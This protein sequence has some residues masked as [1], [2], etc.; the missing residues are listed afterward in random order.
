MLT[1]AVCLLVLLAV[2]TLFYHQASVQVWSVASAIALVLLFRFNDSLL[3]NV[4]STVLVA[5]ILLPLSM[6][7]IRRKYFSKKAFA[8]FK[9]IMPSMSET[10]KEAL[11]AGTVTWEGD[12]FG[13][14]PDISALFK[15]TPATL[16]KREKT[17]L[18]KEVNALC[19]LVNDWKVTHEDLDLSEETWQYIKD[20][21]FLGM[22]IPESYGGLNF[23]ASAQS[24]IL[25]R[26]YSVSVTLGTTVCVPN[27]LGPAELL[28]KY[29]TKAQKE[30][31][32]PRLAKG[33]DIPCF[34]LTGPNAGSDAASIPDTGIICRDTFNGEEVIGIRLNW[35]KRYITLAPVATVLGLA[36]RLFDPENL[37][38]DEEDIGITCALIPVETK[39]VEIGRR[40]F[41][42]NTSFMNGPTK[43]KDVFIPLDY[44]I[45]GQSMAGSGW[46]MLMECLGA[47]RAISLPSSAVGGCQMATFVT[48]AYA[49]VRE[50]FGTAI[51]NFEG[52]EEPLA[53]IAARTY[54]T[55]S[56][57]KMTV[58]AIDRGE[59]PAVASGILKY[60]ATE[61]GRQV[62]L[63]AMDI[64]GGK[65][66]C[67]G[68]N[69]Y[70]GRG[71]QSAPI[72]I[73]VE[74]ANILTRCLIIFGQGAI[75]CHPY[76]LKELQA[77]EK[78]DLK[79]FD[80]A[81]FGHIGHIFS[82]ASR[83]LVLGATDGRLVSYERG[84]LK[85]P[86]QL[87]KR[88]SSSLAFLSDY[89][90]IV[91]GASLKRKEKISAR[92]GDVLSLLYLA[93]SVI[94]Q[95][96]DDGRPSEDI[97]LLQWSFEQLF[98]E[99]EE[100]LDG[101]ISNFKMLGSR[102]LLKALIFPAGKLRR[103]PSDKLGRTV[104]QL[105]SEDTKTR[106]RLSEFV[107][108]EAC[109]NS[110]THI[111]DDAFKRVLAN[112]ELEKRLYKARKAGQLTGLTLYELMDDALA[113][114]QISEEE[115]TSLKAMEEARQVVIAVDD[116]SKTELLHPSKKTTRAIQSVG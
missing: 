74:G 46:R 94:K 91:L 52:I 35:D 89:A 96:H 26:L 17:F 87:I 50:Q 41:P 113:K 85:R 61:L 32:L 75:R 76:V 5:T 33:L 10:E 19:A 49:R 81:L 111:V 21:G 110:T 54:I 23:S 106:R 78:D 3:T 83:S 116:F 99:I 47:G 108:T 88:Y 44:I 112:S 2:V 56:A 73:T 18:D 16:S 114:K 60:H 65:G 71:Y 86:V 27:S 64:H 8:I 57:L 4:L 53:R 11:N 67:L 7:N 107:F 79:A 25:C 104:A 55:S 14:D 66:I 58:A 63:D 102:L 13:G 93:S 70:L 22:I 72:S 82:Q 37:I 1:V 95:Y 24:A 31:Y 109:D 103:K 28:L 62:A 51:A 69:N 43:G 100:A 92:L 42:L 20:H 30:Y 15:R 98:Y 90:M 97:P 105:I 84:E 48:G 6:V 101:I 77:A 68:P 115:Y 12:L 36:F 9:K 59:K 29:G 45:G 34:A 39:G 40:H 80:K 38:G